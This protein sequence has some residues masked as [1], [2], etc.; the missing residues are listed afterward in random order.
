MINNQEQQPR[1]P[2]RREVNSW[3]G[4]IMGAAVVAGIGPPWKLFLPLGWANS[5]RVLNLKK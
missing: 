5:E 4:G 2:T 3:L 1:N